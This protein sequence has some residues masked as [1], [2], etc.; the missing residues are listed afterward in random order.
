MAG[1]LD[2]TLNLTRIDW[3][4]KWDGY[5][6]IVVSIDGKKIIDKTDVVGVANGMSGQVDCGNFNARWSTPVTVDVKI[7]RQK[8]WIGV[9][10]TM[11]AGQY[12]FST[13]PESLRGRK[14]QLRSSQQQE[15]AV[16]FD[17]TGEPSNHRY[18]HGEDH[19]HPLL[20]R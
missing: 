5:K 9:G 20:R 6:T 13:T 7:V 1:P 2:L 16:T 18:H 17:V 10:S 8:W 14:V 11:D 4:S 3:G 15:N 12:Q 19:E